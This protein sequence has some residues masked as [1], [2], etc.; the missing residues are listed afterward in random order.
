MKH[1]NELGWADILITLQER[2]PA[3][4][5]EIIET[6]VWTVWPRLP[7]EI[8]QR[9]LEDKDF[10][11]MPVY[12]HPS[13]FYMTFDPPLKHVVV[14][15]LREEDSTIQKA[16]TLAHEIAHWVAADKGLA[17]RDAEAL[18]V[19]WG[20]QHE[21]ESVRY[22][23]PIAEEKGFNVGYKW[24][25][26]ADDFDLEPFIKHF[27]QWKKEDEFPFFEDLAIEIGL[28]DILIDEGI[29][30]DTDEVGEDYNH[31]QKGFVWGVMN[32]L[33]NREKANH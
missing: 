20:F 23:N 16:H 3:C 32:Y 5:P 21:V 22:G 2:F 26:R 6:L 7:K 28:H 25:S 17:E 11:L 14:V 33:S 10:Q 27:N 1:M 30:E 15:N 29:I 13:G 18:I 4:D 8:Q 9:L 12:P 31:F 24:A 19:K